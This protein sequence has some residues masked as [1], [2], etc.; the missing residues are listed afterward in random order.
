MILEGLTWYPDGSR[1]IFASR[2]GRGP[3]Q[4]AYPGKVVSVS[5]CGHMA[6][7]RDRTLPLGEGFFLGGFI[8][9]CHAQT[10]VKVAKLE[11]E[12]KKRIDQ[13]YRPDQLLLGL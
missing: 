10:F 1:I 3:Y 7:K 13:L 11:T 9:T 6:T 8:P 5:G 2:H 4:P 12:M